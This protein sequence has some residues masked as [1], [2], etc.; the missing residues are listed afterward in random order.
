M[1]KTFLLTIVF[2]LCFGLQILNCFAQQDQIN[3]QYLI[4]KYNLSPAFTGHNQNFEVFAGYRQNWSDIDGAPVLKMLNINGAMMKNS[5][6]GV[7]VYNYQ[8]GIFSSLSAK[9]NYA[10]RISLGKKNKL[11]FG[12]GA[13]I[14]DSRA[15]GI[16]FSENASDP[17]FAEMANSTTVPDF[18]FGANLQLK[19]LSI[20]VAANHL[21]SAEKKQL[22][23]NTVLI[24]YLSYQ[25]KM[26]EKIESEPTVLI[27]NS[28]DSKMFYEISYL[29]KYQKK[30]WLALTY[31]K[32]SQ[33][34][35]TFGF[36]FQNRLALNYSYELGSSGMLGE[37]SGTHELTL[38]FFIGKNENNSASSIFNNTS[39][40]ASYYK[41]LE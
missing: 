33:I 11:S 27:R 19:K 34:A 3:N 39:K 40:K 29:V 6:I 14:F 36:L 8:I 24:G 13:G 41:W 17:V 18:D 4:N 1:K 22:S 37:S 38:G 10:H 26:S 9:A 25:Y 21:M 30:V 12:I 32:E 5:G 35:A 28:P 15:N 2:T 7:S 16:D 20:G 31:K 23:L